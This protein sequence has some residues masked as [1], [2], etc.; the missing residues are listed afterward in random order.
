MLDLTI[1]NG[2]GKL[3]TLNTMYWGD[4][5]SKKIKIGSELEF[6]LASDRYETQ[7]R[8][9]DA[10]KPTG[11][12][13]KYGNGVYDIKGDGSLD[14]GIEIEVIGRTTDFLSTY[15]NMKYIT[16]LLHSDASTGYRCGLHQHIL[17]N[18]D[19]YS[20]ELER[21]VPS[22]IYSN[23]I[24]IHRMFAPALVWLFSNANKGQRDIITRYE[25]Y[26]KAEML[27]K[28]TPVK[29]PERFMKQIKESNHKYHFINTLHK[30]SD[31]RKEIEKFHYEVRQADGNLHPSVITAMA[32]MNK[33][34]VLKAIQ[35][36]EFGILET[37]SD[38]F[39]NVKELYAAIRNRDDV[40]YGSD[41]Y[42]SMPNEE[43][44]GEIQQLCTQFL[45]FMK[46]TY[47]RQ[48]LVGHKILEELNVEPCSIRNLT[49]S[50]EQIDAYFDNYI[51][52]YYETLFK[53]DDVV[54]K[55]FID[56]CLKKTKAISKEQW[57]YLFSQANSLD[58]YELK[59]KISM[60]EM[61]G[62]VRFDLALGTYIGSV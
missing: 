47:S 59:Q 23:I 58:Y 13:N 45:S 51:K 53:K 42:S 56:I 2:Y 20:N 8:L 41:R 36:S 1:N 28:Y 49:Q 48:D 26:C 5:F 15:S 61:Q 55:L 17:I 12:Y 50:R 44:I 6:E 52:G 22:I 21:P 40:R 25:Y 31:N 39:N 57:F 32:V 62:F 4:F 19:N 29:E 33:N 38:S 18:N 34:I 43:K 10:L 46:D 24:A 7:S 35:I 11:N 3:S 14:N 54:N 9:Q 30:F 37:N 27:L 16:S 60:L